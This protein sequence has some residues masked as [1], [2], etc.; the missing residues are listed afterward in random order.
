METPNVITQRSLKLI[1][2]TL[3]SEHKALSSP[4]FVGAFIVFMAFSNQNE[5]LV[6]EKSFSTAIPALNWGSRLVGWFRG[7]KM[8]TCTARA[9]SYRCS[10]V[11]LISTC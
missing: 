5:E 9:L 6:K 8:A 3:V 11:F 10:S 7:I 4:S 2:V 1:E